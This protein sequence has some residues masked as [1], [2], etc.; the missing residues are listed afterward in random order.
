MIVTGSSNTRLPELRNYKI[1]SSWYN[2]YT[3]GGSPT[4]DG[5][6]VGSSSASHIEY[7]IG[8]I[9]YVDEIGVSGTTT[10]FSFT[11]KGTDSSDFV[12]L[13]YYKDPNESKI[14]SNPKINDD[15]FIIREELSAFDKNYKLEYVSNMIDLITYAGGRYFN[16]INN[17]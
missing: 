15:V 17:T 5:I 14:I 1:T 11:A 8:G 13:P 3:T 7:Y 4:Q 6:V 12:N 10:T 9:L 16:I 2:K